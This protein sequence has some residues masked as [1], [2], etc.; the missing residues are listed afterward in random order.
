[1]YVERIFHRY[2]IDGMAMD[3]IA[4]RL[5][6]DPEAPSPPKSTYG[7]AGRTPRYGVLAKARYR[8]F[9]EYG[10]TQAVYQSVPDYIRQ[11]RRDAP[12]QAAFIEDLRIVS[13]DIWYRTQ[14]ML[15]EERG[16]RGRK[17]TK[18][19]PKFRPKLLNGMLYCPVH[20]RPLQTGGSGNR[21]MVCKLCRATECET[22]PLYTQLDGAA[23]RLT[24]EKLTESLRRRRLPQHDRRGLSPRG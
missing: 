16:D 20:E 18:S 9:W 5:N 21:A 12:L 17:A 3:A 23:L 13:D 22:R 14:Q 10:V 24:L 11:V 8:G 19:D 15:L 1:M 6:D 4:R 2:L 7:T